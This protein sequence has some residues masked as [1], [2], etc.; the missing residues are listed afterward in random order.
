MTTIANSKNSIQ[1]Q[2]QKFW[3]LEEVIEPKARKRY[4]VEEIKCETHFLQTCSREE[5]GRFTLKLPF[6]DNIQQLGESRF[7]ATKRFYHMERK[8]DEKPELKREY[9]KFMREY[10]NLGHMTRMSNSKIH[11]KEQPQVFLPHHPVIRA[12]SSTTKLRVMFDASAK[13]SSNISLNDTLMIGPTIQDDLR[14]ILMRFR[15]HQVVLTADV[16]KM[17]RQINVSDD[18][19]S[20]QQILWREDANDPLEVYHLKTITYGTSAAPFMAIRTLHLLADCERKDLDEAA[21]IT[22][23]DFYVDNLLTGSSNITEAVKIQDEML[24]LCKRGGL[25]LRKWCSNRKEL[26]TR[27]P[28][29]L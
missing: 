19:R 23:R 25:L 18:C 27:I 21:Q 9:I 13:T 26:L 22:K 2:V 7:I 5:N 15:V 8:L 6:R 20:Y 12:E 1:N 16:E 14:G 3:E 28:D 11:T 17:Y 24:E 4:T 29:N 10:Q